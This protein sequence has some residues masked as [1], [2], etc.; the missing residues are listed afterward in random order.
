LLS[1][2][3]AYCYAEAHTLELLNTRISTRM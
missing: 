1:P 2:A 3:P